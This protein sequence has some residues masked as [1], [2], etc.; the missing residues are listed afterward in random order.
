MHQFKHTLSYLIFPVLAMFL[1]T[2]CGENQPQRSSDYRNS[3]IT[4]NKNASKSEIIKSAVGVVPDMRQYEW[5]KMEF[6]AFA[7]F[8]MNTFTGREWGTGKE[9]PKL[10]NPTNF[11]A[12]QWA[13]TAKKASMKMIMLTA[14]HHDGFCLWPTATT[15]HSV[16]NSPWKDGKGDVFKEVADASRKAGLKVGVYVSPAD[17]SEIEREGGTYGNG[18]KPKTV[19]IPAYGDA[20]NEVGSFTYDNCTDYDALFLTQIYEVCSKYGEI[21]EIWFDGANPKPGT[22]QV[23]N[24]KAWF[25]LIRK[26]Q[27]NCVIA[28]H[29]PDV[30]WC[31]NEGGRT[32]TSEFS[33]VPTNKENILDNATKNDLGS[34]EKLYKANFLH[35]YPAETNT[36]IRHGW[37]YRDDNQYV[38]STSELLDNWY[39]AVGG[40][41]VFLL[42]V[43]PNREGLIPAKDSTNLV[44]LGKIIYDSFTKNLIDDE[45]ICTADN[46]KELYNA[47]YAVDG[48]IKTA[49]QTQEGVET[50]VLT[51]DLNKEATFNRVVLQE[52]IYNLS[53]RVEAFHIDY[54]KDGKWNLLVK[55]KTIGFK[56]ISRFPTITTNKIRIVIDKSRVTATLSEVGLYLAPERLEN[57]IITRTKDGMVSIF[58]K[59]GDSK[60]FYTIDGSAPTVDSKSFTESFTLPNGGVIKAISAVNNNTDLSDV[61][62]KTFDLCSSKW[63]L[64]EV[65]DFNSSNPGEK[66]FDGNN[67]TM[68]HT[69]WH[70]DSKKHPHHITINLGEEVKL[71]GF[72]YT[73]RQDGSKSG[74]CNSYLFEVSKDGKRWKKMKQDR[75]DNIQ[76]NPVQQRVFFK[77]TPAKYIRF[78]SKS[79]LGNVNWL[80]TAEVGVIVDHY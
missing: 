8:G 1:A 9:D 19:T 27:P 4:V 22:G 32:R 16:K 49:W 62:D 2:S 5:Q 33:V 34:R 56:H 47:K 25:D 35:W 60:I 57:P 37:F 12:N 24:E 18:S 36:S 46:T 31:G 40:N 26:L 17:L 76:N 77:S 42:N 75:F 43:T 68:W 38:K 63:T 64:V 55:N 70:K 10:F 80:S 71:K 41:S 51:I 44:N 58:T 52:D 39:R 72:T 20:V 79:A 23:Y 45:A 29:G 78:T 48:D 54:F 3:T 59:N 15:P 74:I 67:R 50:G 21:S 13:I 73:P 66:A 61:V 6:I 28:I 69:H 7:H 14:K 30:R 11:D 65:D 53:Q